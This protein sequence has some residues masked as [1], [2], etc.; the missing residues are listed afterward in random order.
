MRGRE[1]VTQNVQSTGAH[2][3]LNT[4]PARMWLRRG[5]ALGRWLRTL[6][7]RKKATTAPEGSDS[8]RSAQARLRL[9]K[10]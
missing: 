2:F 3:G 6:P 4:I 7:P 8:P 1:D 10:I 9:K 5:E